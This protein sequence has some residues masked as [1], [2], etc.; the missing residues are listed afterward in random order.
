MSAKYLFE[1]QRL[2]FRRWKESDRNPFAA[3]TAD[4]EVMRYFPKLVEKDEADRLIER[5]ETHM[6]NKGFTMWAVD[7]KKDG[8]FIG[9]IGLLEITMPIEGQGAAEIGWR[10]DKRFWKQGYAVEGAQA[11]LAY[12]FGP[13]GMTEVYSF[14]S[15]INQPSEAVMKRIGMTKIDEFEHPNLDRGSPLKTHVLYKIKRQE[16]GRWIDQGDE[17]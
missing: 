15:V 4:P 3:M 7:R 1:S 8:A 16:A 17:R 6:D 14:T 2:G 11:C 9:F 12:A 5:F 10:L 13:L